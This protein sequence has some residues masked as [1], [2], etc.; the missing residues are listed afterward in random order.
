MGF[1]V[2]LQKPKLIFIKPILGQSRTPV[3]TKLLPTL[4]NN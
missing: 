3:P 4:F 1:K 2:L